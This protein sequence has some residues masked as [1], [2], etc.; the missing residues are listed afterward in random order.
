MD[1]SSRARNVIF[2][3]VKT[4]EDS[5]KMA[6]QYDDVDHKMRKYVEISD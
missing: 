1:K 6:I 3:I 2:P 4:S 5:L